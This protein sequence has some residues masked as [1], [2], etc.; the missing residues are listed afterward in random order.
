MVILSTALFF[1]IH[2]FIYKKS[3]VDQIKRLA[4]NDPSMVNGECTL[5]ISES[6]MLREFRNSTNKLK[7]DEIKLVSEDDD[8]YILY[9]SDIQASVIKKKPHNMSEEEIQKYNQ[10]LR[11]Y[12]NQYNIDV[13]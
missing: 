4:K 9:M 11:N 1:A 8:R 5:T 13:E 2:N 3:M 7:W 6:G 12:F 10:L